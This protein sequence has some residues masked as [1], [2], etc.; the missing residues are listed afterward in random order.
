M[1]PNASPSPA[2]SSDRLRTSAWL[3]G[4]AAAGAAASAEAATVQIDL[5][6]NGVTFATS[7]LDD[8]TYRDL[9][10]DGVDD[11]VGSSNLSFR[12]AK[13]RGGIEGVIEGVRVG[14]FFTTSSST[15]TTFVA[16][17]GSADSSDDSPVSIRSFVPLSFSDPRINGGAK[18]AGRIE[19]LARNNSASSHEI[20]L[21][22]LVFDDENTD[23]QERVSTSLVYP[24][25]NDVTVQSQPVP[26]KAKGN[27]A[28]LR[29]KRQIAALEAQ[30]RKIKATAK[31]NS[32]RLNFVGIDPATYRYLL[33][34]ERRLAALKQQLRRL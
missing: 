5:T 21:I 25:W 24:T 4:T 8:Q 26:T 28:K 14:A 15:S 10:G 18:T 12:L 23:L 11:L 7:S 29:L 30:I 20:Q 13:A 32:P 9:T 27:A 1:T 16:F 2:L 31:P 17:V 6:G 33:S 22:R 3:L 19:V 34:L